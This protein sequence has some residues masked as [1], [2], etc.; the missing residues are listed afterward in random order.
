VVVII[1]W[2]VINLSINGTLSVK[3]ELMPVILYHSLNQ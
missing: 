3:S 1:G 2:Q